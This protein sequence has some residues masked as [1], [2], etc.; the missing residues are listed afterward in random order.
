MISS[1]CAPTYVT[2]AITLVFTGFAVVTMLT[3][4]NGYVQ[5]TTDPALRGRVLALYMAILLGGT[6]VGAPIVGWMVDQF[7]TRV[8]IFVAAIMALIA[9]GIGVMWTIVSGRLHRHETRRFRLP[10]D[11]PRPIDPADR[12]SVV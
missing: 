11:W 9:C 5:T 3:T 6:P 7:G 1:G 4:S 2:S 12:E 8:A 10:L